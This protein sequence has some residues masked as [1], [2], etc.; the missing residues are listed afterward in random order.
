MIKEL[1]DFCNTQSG[2]CIVC[3]TAPSLLNF[4]EVKDSC[5]FPTIGVNNIGGTFYPDYVVVVDPIGSFQNYKLDMMRNYTMPFF[6]PHTE[7]WE[8]IFKSDLVKFNFAGYDLGNFEKVFCTNDVN[9]GH[10]SVYCA[11]IIASYL[12]FRR[13][14]LIGCDIMTC[15]HSYEQNNKKHPLSRIFNTIDKEFNNLNKAFHSKGVNVYN[16]SKESAITA[17]PKMNL[18]KFLD[19]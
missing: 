12:G 17:F 16:L 5:K 18:K 13:I 6:T 1:K 9:V 10:T 7:G 8:S 15:G 3:G 11:L 19:E 14:G 4:I 2:S